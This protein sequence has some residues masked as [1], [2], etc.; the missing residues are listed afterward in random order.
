MTDKDF[1]YNSSTINAF[2]DASA[3]EASMFTQVTHSNSNASRTLNGNFQNL[4]KNPTKTQNHSQDMNSTNL[5]SHTSSNA[6]DSKNDHGTFPGYC[7]KCRTQAKI[8]ASSY[9]RNTGDSTSTQNVEGICDNDGCPGYMGHAPSSRLQRT[10]SHTAQ[11]IFDTGINSDGDTSDDVPLLITG[12]ESNRQNDNKSENDGITGIM[13]NS[14]EEEL[15]AMDH[16]HSSSSTYLTR[17][18]TTKKAKKQ[19]TIACSLCLIFIAG[20]IVG[21]KISNSLAIMTDAAHMLSDFATFCVSLFSIWMG[22]KSARKS[23][24]YGFRRAEAVGALFTIM[25]IWFVTGILF[26]LACQRL[27]TGSFEVDPD[28]MMAVAGCAVVFNIV[29]GIVLHGLPHGHTH[30]GMSH[31]S[32]HGHG[33]GD[34]NH[35]HS[36]IG[37]PGSQR[38]TLKKAEAR[39]LN[40]RAALIHVLGDFIQ[41]IGVLIS[42]VIIKIW[43]QAKNADPLCTLLFSVIVMFTTV[44]VVKDVVR[45]LMEGHPRNHCY[46]EIYS[47]LLDIKNVVRVHDLRVWSLSVDYVVL[48]AHLA[49]NPE[50]TSESERILQVGLKDNGYLKP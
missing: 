45:I 19:L 2:D 18:L 36:H 28:P 9:Q 32:S 38:R 7:I 48:T 40:V 13:R 49:V 20:E 17:K 11:D 16:C 42:A 5:A 23:F 12:M 4:Q 1:H 47:A 27:A 22:E 25:I 33:L 14:S 21:G 35:N 10:Y 43:P 46:D 34:M 24:N 41:S 39:H 3:A 15:V 8:G 30:G 37:E 6:L 50:E 44:Y 26:Y 29:I 31:A